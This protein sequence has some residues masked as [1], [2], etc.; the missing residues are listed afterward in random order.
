MYEVNE[1]FI[2]PYFISVVSAVS[3]IRPISVSVARWEPRRT[4]VFISSVKIPHF[5]NVDKNTRNRSQNAPTLCFDWKALIDP[6]YA[7]VKCRIQLVFLRD[8]NVN[9]VD[10]KPKLIWGQR[11]KLTLSSSWTFEILCLG[12]WDKF[13]QCV[14]LR[15]GFLISPFKFRDGSAFC[16]I[17]NFIIFMILHD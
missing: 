11:S 10:E 2:S 15:I 12:S 5:R 14:F 4:L 7:E 9:T 13:F 3:V 17:L 8:L 6:Q 1:L 16:N